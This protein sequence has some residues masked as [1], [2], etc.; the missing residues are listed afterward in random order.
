[1]NENIAHALIQVT[2]V[3]ADEVKIEVNIF[4]RLFNNRI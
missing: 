4:R 1:M 2:I 3:K